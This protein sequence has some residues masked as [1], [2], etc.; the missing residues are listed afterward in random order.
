M[1]PTLLVGA[2]AAHSVESLV[3]MAARGTR[4]ADVVEVRLDAVAGVT[5]KDLTTI[6]AATDA[7][8]ILTCRCREQGGAFTGSESER[9]A[10]L[11]RGGSLGF[12][13]IDV[14]IAAVASIDEPFAKGDAELILSH[15]DFDGLPAEP[16]ALVTQAVELGADIVKI[17]ARV[18]SLDEVW[19]LAAMG[20]LVRAEGKRFV[21]VAMGPAGVAARILS[22]RFGAHLT[23]AAAGGG[24]P[25]GPG[26]LD[27]D[28]MVSL[29]RFASIGTGTEVY[30]I[31]GSHALTSRSPRMHNPF[32]ESIGRDA[33]Y[34]PFEETDLEAF[35]RGAK[36]LEIAGLSVT[37]PFK[38][39]IV[40]FLDELDDTAA[41]IGA[42]NTVVVRGGRWKGYNTDIDGIV[43]PLERAGEWRGRP[44]VVV[45]S[46]GAARAAVFALDRLGASVTVLA[47]QAARSK[48]LAAEIGGESGTLS[49]LGSARWDLLVNA[50]PVGSAGEDGVCESLP[51]G[52]IRPEQCVFDMVTAPEQTPLIRRARERGARTITGIEM[53]A[54]Q[55]VHQAKLWTGK[56]PQVDELAGNARFVREKMTP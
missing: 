12:D 6:R 38:E 34:V 13:Y 11:A 4:G 37:L 35:V 3:R 39:S 53:L 24:P 52:T 40:P 10:L 31:L 45:G 46:G 14:E 5:E 32:F 20:E 21:P 23:Y 26:Q 1:T 16:E 18:S 33:V 56:T 2:V 17:A 22:A 55:A 48:S 49:E 9:L 15:H 7:P 43:E 42:V 29:Y 8:M 30:G 47:R 36:R 25:T 51:V 19:P 44:A 41:E 50:T 28:D 54:A 27:L